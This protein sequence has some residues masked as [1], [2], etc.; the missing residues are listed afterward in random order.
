MARPDSDALC[1]LLEEGGALPPDA[2]AAFL[3]EACTGH[4]ELRE[5][6]TSL[7]AAHDAA[8][9]YFERVTEQVIGPAL[10]AFADDVEVEFSTGRTI[11]QY[12]LLERLG[13]GG[14]G[15]VFKALDCAWTALLLSSS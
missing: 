12:R 1:A 14:M 13:G 4:G 10:V 6:L 11:A 2:R 5:E 15:I 9:D 8:S 3:D 7:L